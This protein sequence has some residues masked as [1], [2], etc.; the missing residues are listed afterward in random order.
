MFHAMDN[1]SRVVY[2]LISQ[3]KHLTLFLE[4]PSKP[5]RL[6]AIRVDAASVMLEWDE[7]SMLGGRKIESRHN[8]SVSV[9]E[10]PHTYYTFD[11]L[12]SMFP[13]S[14]KVRALTAYGWGTWSEPLWYQPGRGQF[15][16][17][18]SGGDGGYVTHEGGF[19]QAFQFFQFG[20]CSENF[21]KTS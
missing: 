2:I 12:N 8:G 13:Y 10:T 11:N 16:P 4:P 9:V 18:N 6:T 21:L 5:S 14:F 19:R 7:P 1:I 20:V 17:P 15:L 3:V